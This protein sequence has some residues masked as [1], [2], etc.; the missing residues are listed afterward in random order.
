MRNIL[1]PT[2]FSANANNAYRYALKLAETVG[3]DIL[4]LHVASPLSVSVPYLSSTVKELKAQNQIDAF[5][6]YREEVRY[7]EPSNVLHRPTEVVVRH[8]L[9]E[10]TEVAQTILEVAQKEAVDW[11]V[12]GTQGATGIKEMIIGSNT[13]RVLEEAP[14]PVLVVPEEAKYHG[15]RKMV[16]ATNFEWL[17]ES[18]MLKVVDLAILLGAELHFLHVNL[19]HTYRASSKM[20]EWKNMLYGKDN[21]YFEIIEG[22]NLEVVQSLENYVEENDIDLLAMLTHK[23][24]FWERI[25]SISYTQKMCFHTHTPLL[26]FKKEE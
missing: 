24:D 23:R 6:K 16:Y 15:L 21:I 19:S 17:E 10:S 3:A 18:Y 12:M 11:I 9:R 5:S 22:L 25:L 4:T 13:A 26:I 8:L 1:F 20:E 7:M 14:C 2:D